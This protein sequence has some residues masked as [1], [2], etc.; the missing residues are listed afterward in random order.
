ML[1]CNP[2]V[3]GRKPA[4]YQNTREQQLFMSTDIKPLGPF[5]WS[6][7]ELLRG[8]FRQSEYGRVVLPFV[9]LRRLDAIQEEMSA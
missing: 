8:D 7:A 5:V 6:I 9:V 3:H 2:H 1:A 4:T